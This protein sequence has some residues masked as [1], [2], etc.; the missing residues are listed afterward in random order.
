MQTRYFSIL[1]AFVLSAVTATARTIEDSVYLSLDQQPDGGVFMPAPPDSLSPLFAGDFLMWQYGKTLRPTARGQQASDESL[2]SP[3][4]VIGISSE[5]LGISITASRTPAIY[6]FLRKAVI[7]GTQSTVKPKAKYMRTRPFAL[8]NEHTWAK[9]DDEA[10]LR[11]NGS[12]PS[13]HTALGWTMAL[14]VAEMAPEYQDT[15]LRRGFM[16]GEDRWIV[17]AHWKSDVDAGYVCASACVA[18]MHANPMYYSDLK[19]ARKEYKRLKGLK[20]DTTTVGYPDGTRILES[21]VDTASIR[22]YTDMAAYWQGKNLR[23]TNPEA[24]QRAITG[25]DGSTKGLLA[26]FQPSAGITL[27]KDSTPAIYA[28]VHY[29]RERLRD[30]AKAMKKTH[31]RKRPF[32]Q[33]GE[34]TLMP[35][36]EKDARSSS[37]YPSSH[38][39]RG[40]GIALLLTELM[41][42]RANAILATGYA[43]GYDR[44]I[45]G[46]HY[47]SDVQA[48][49]LVAAYTMAR[50]HNDRKFIELMEAARAEYKHFSDKK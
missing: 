50:L 35:E 20:A 18:R 27:S 36:H 40:W 21:P 13:G 1:L 48:G 42:D 45:A 7:T 44:V 11:T 14:V 9:Y 4:E 3:D 23:T 28:V 30:E 2:W 33:L 8:M 25:A 26:Y 6:R 34:P 38:S 5:V 49:R 16:F 17:G 22:F 46:Y 47:A 32:V 12:Y 24:A 10:M 29:A 39:V 15:I 43:Y 37:S 41:P 19:A 31:F